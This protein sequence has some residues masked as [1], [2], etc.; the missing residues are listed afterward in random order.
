MVL[1][2]FFKIKGMD[3]MRHKNQDFHS[4][5]FTI[6]PKNRFI[7]QLGISKT[8]FAK[9]ASYIKGRFNASSMRVQT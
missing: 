1:V 9:D 5:S 4:C 8:T 3:F 7:Y 6:F 2:H